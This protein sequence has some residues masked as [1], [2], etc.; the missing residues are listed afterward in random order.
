M[1]PIYYNYKTSHLNQH[2]GLSERPRF[3]TSLLDRW[4]YPELI[5]LLL[6]VS[7]KNWAGD[8]LLDLT[9]TEVRGLDLLGLICGLFG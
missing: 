2:L 1:L 6:E 5:F 8:G 3:L 9:L 7:S 4:L